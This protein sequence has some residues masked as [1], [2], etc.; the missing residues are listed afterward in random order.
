MYRVECDIVETLAG[1]LQ[2][3]R[4]TLISPGL[5]PGAFAHGKRY[6]EI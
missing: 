3:L 1:T 5:H 6:T 4:I 2:L